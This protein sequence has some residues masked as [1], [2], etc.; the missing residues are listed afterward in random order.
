MA[1]CRYRRY[2]PVELKSHRSHDVV[3]LCIDCHERAHVAAERLMRRLATEHGVP[4]HQTRGP[5]SPPARA[6]TPHQL[7][8]FKVA[9]AAPELSRGVD[10]V[11]DA[12]AGLGDAAVVLSNGELAPSSPAP[13]GEGSDASSSE[14]AEGPSPRAARLAALALRK[15]TAIPDERRAEL[16]AVVFR[17][18]PARVDRM[19]AL[20]CE[21]AAASLAAGTRSRAAGGACCASVGVDALR[22]RRSRAI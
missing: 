17:C 3:L 22:C 16:V 20:A 19:H 9:V 18:A 15:G 5:R 4:L 12:S 2:F 14:A 8:G 10:P 7:D 1:A 11:S 6:A 21:Q 13:T